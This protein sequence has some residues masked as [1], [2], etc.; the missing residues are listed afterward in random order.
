MNTFL[1]SNILIPQVDSMEQ[2]AV[3]ACDQFSSQPE[4]WEK[5]KTE[6]KNA[7]SALNLILP[8]VYLGTKKEAVH[9]AKIR[10]TMD[11]Y[12]RNNIFKT[13]QQAFIYVERTLGNGTIR[14]GLVGAIDLEN[15]SY[16]MEDDAKIRATEKTVMERI[17]PRMN[18]RYNAAIELPHVILLCDD[19]EQILMDSVSKKKDQLPKLYDFELMEDGGHIAGWLVQGTAVKEFNQKLEQYEK[20]IKEK[21]RDITNSPMVFAVGDGNHSLA[22]AKAC[23]EKLKR[24][25]PDK[26]LSD[27]PARYALVELENLHD[28]S[29][30]FEP[31]HRII[32]GVDEKD[33]LEQLMNTCCI[34]GGFPVKW[35]SG[36]KEGEIFLDLEKNQ[37]AVGKLQ[38]FLDDYLKE[39]GGEIDYIHGDDVLKKLAAKKH[40]IGF[41]LPAMEKEDLFPSVMENGVL[42]RKTFSMGHAYE[43]RYYIE[44]RV[45]K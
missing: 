10:K 44:G 33:L 45:I 30:N 20:T 32:T 7:P 34:E 11:G 3:I 36:K 29:Q 6:V 15:Y 4:Y 23:Y 2:W 14:R 35:C 38:I 16:T 43:K 21:Y 13:Y 40:S 42:P 17:P 24:T 25:Y 27:H 26:D 19:L 41:L 1:P 39:N 8:E 9:I 31:I 22:T 37:L 12:L 5:V 28:E 18:I